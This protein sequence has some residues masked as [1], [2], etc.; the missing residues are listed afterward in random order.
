MKAI[1]SDS[2]DMYN[3]NEL[4]KRSYKKSENEEFVD[5]VSKKELGHLVEVETVKPIKHGKIYSNSS[6]TLRPF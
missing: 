1:K 4:A 6:L 2:Q 3:A 5:A